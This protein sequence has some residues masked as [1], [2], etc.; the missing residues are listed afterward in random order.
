MDF[1]G[2]CPA[3]GTVPANRRRTKRNLDKRDPAHESW[4]SRCNEYSPEGAT[5]RSPGWSE[6]RAEPW[7]NWAHMALNPEGV[8]Q[9]GEGGFPELSMPSLRD[10]TIEK[11]IQPRVH[12]VHRWATICRPSGAIR[13]DACSH[14]PIISPNLQNSSQC[15]PFPRSV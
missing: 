5:N 1:C 8:T 3:S 12:F 10:S 14:A 13:R 2:E 11:I 7:V 9:E 4:C 6:V 15:G